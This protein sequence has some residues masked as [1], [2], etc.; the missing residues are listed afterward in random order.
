MRKLA[1]QTG[2]PSSETPSL[3]TAVARTDFGDGPSAAD[4]YPEA[5]DGRYISADDQAML[6]LKSVVPF[7]G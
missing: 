6:L 2:T 3:A 1:P 5:G 7:P 4:D